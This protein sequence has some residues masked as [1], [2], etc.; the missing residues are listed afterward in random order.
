MSVRVRLRLQTERVKARARGRRVAHFLHPGK[1]AG[2]A[3]KHALKNAPPSPRFDLELHTHGV[4][5]ADLPRGDPFFFV[6][7]DPVDRFVS[8]FWGRQRQ[9]RP[10]HNNPW[11]PDEAT[12]FERFATPQ[13]LADALGGSADDRAAAVHALGAID[14]VRTSYWYWFGDPDAFR[15]RSSDVLFIGYQE[16]LDEQLPDLALALGLPSLE[17]PHDDVGANRTAPSPSA[18]AAGDGLTDQ[19]RARMR[20][21]FA[22]DYE[23]VD[24]C[25]AIKPPPSTS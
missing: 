17:V 11:S 10:R 9:G 4:R 2:T 22:A 7:R 14:H 24:L 12:A 13:A 1:T 5:M 23:F 16:T 20:E 8:G 3:V 21:W 6:V 15:R 25:R 19:A 18:A